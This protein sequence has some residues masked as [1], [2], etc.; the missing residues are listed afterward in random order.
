MDG[1][2]VQ[3]G[4]WERGRNKQEGKWLARSYVPGLGGDVGTQ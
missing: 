4:I 1:V 2:K 3:S